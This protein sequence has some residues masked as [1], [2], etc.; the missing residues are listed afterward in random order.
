MSSIQNNEIVNKNA[1]EYAKFGMPIMP[2]NINTA[3]YCLPNAFLDFSQNASV[4]N[5][6]PFMEQRCASTWDNKCELYVN[7]FNNDFTLIT[8]FTRNA[9][10]RRFCKLASNS[11]C[12]VEC[13]P[14]DP[15]IET[16]DKVCV[17]KG[18]EA[19][20]NINDSVDIGLNTPVIISPVYIGNCNQTC[21]N[22]NIN[23]IEDNDILINLAIKYNCCNDILENIIVNS[24]N[25]GITNESVFKNKKLESLFK[26]IY[27]NKNNISATEKS[28]N[29]KYSSI[30]SND[31]KNNYILYTLI[32]LL[33][34]CI[35]IYLRK[36]YVKYT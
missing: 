23:D 31:N 26:L 27:N 33:V 7:S 19:L 15:I 10:S 24:I 12:N 16:S 32:I 36:K 20:T 4:G 25:K 30:N 28:N 1:D 21:D 17:N 2:A 18:R 8:N 34:I 29:V 22:V 9:L 11:R 3:D 5:C 14:F 35:V 6:P 13:Q